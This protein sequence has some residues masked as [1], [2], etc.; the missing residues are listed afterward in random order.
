ML[1]F[2]G[3]SRSSEPLNID[4]SRIIRA[5]FIR[6]LRLIDNREY[7]VKLSDDSEHRLSAWPADP[8]H[9]LPAR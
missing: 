3:D 6:E 9:P 8:R 7:G 5:D 1:D 2:S 4:R